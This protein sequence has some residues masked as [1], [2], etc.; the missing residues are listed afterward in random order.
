MDHI[1]CRVTAHAYNEIFPRSAVDRGLSRPT[2]SDFSIRV[3]VVAMSSGSDATRI[4][5]S[6]LVIA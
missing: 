4:R 6:V 2:T 5:R 3:V 1:R